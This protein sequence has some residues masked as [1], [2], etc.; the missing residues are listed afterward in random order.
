M[1]RTRIPTAP[2]PPQKQSAAGRCP[3]IP[4][5]VKLAL[6]HIREDGHELPDAEQAAIPRNVAMFASRVKYCVTPN[7]AKKAGSLVMNVERAKASPS[8]S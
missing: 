6:V 8:C 5:T 7:H 2:A 4:L 3:R 1:D